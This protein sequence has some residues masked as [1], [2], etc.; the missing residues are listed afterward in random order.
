MCLY[1]KHDWIRKAAKLWWYDHDLKT[2]ALEHIHMFLVRN[3]LLR[4]FR[5]KSGLDLYVWFV[6]IMLE[7]C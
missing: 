2:W 1:D 6:G 3:N 7:K 4:M 5:N